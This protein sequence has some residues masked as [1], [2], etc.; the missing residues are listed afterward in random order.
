[1]FDCINGTMIEPIVLSVG[2][3]GNVFLPVLASVVNV[4]VLAVGPTFFSSS[5]FFLV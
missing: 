2:V 4:V 1:M 5:T 3:A